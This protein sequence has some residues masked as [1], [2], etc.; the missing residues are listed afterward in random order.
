A[1][2]VTDAGGNVWVADKNNRRI[3]KFSATGAFVL[4]AG[5]GVSD[6]M[7]HAEICTASCNA[8]ISGS[9]AG[10]FTSPQGIATDHAGNV[11]VADAVNDR[12]EKFSKA[13]G[14]L[15]QWGSSG[16]RRG[17][18]SAP[19]GVATNPAGQ[20]YIADSQNGRVEKF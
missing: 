11:Y 10:Q 7:A 15:K 6:N 17:Q 4:A 2:I 18:F 16:S 5:W 20:V 14:F 9:G 12:V 13:G 3:D 19:V 8:G 1:G